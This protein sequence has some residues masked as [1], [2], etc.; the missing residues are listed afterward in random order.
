M[1][2]II[3]YIKRSFMR[4]MLVGIPYMEHMDF[5]YNQYNELVFIVNIVTT[6]TSSS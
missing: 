5:V 3:T 1:Y 4:V 2:S 6:L